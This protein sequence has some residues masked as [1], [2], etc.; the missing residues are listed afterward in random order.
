[1]TDTLQE[2]VD[3]DEATA[4]DTAVDKE[5]EPP[6][7]PLVLRDYQ[8]AAADA[9]INDWG[10]D[11]RR[12][13]VVLPTGSGKTAVAAEVVRRAR[14]KG[15]RVVM[16]AHR[17]ELLGQMRNAVHAVDPDIGEVGVVMAEYNDPDPDIVVASFQTLAS[18]PKRL[19]ALGKRD[20]IVVDEC[21][22]ITAPTYM[23]VL[24]RLGAG[25]A[26]PQAEDESTTPATAFTLGL[27]A[28][29]YRSDGTALGNVWENVCFER[30]IEWAIDNGFLV[31]PKAK[32]VRVP[33]L[34]G[35][36]SIMTVAGDYNKAQLS[37]IMAKSA[38][39]N[40][41]VDAVKTHAADR[42][43]IVFAASV[44]H[45]EVLAEALTQA[46]VPSVS[47]TGSDPRSVRAERYEKFHSGEVGALVTVMVLTE[48]AD[49]PRCDCVVMARP[50]RSQVL[51]SQMI[52]RALR[53]YTDPVTGNKKTDALVLDLTGT[54]RDKKLVTL[55]DLWG[56]A[57]TSSY[58]P[59]GNLLPDPEV[60][61]DLP[62]VPASGGET[63][64]G[65][66]AGDVDLVDYDL[67]RS[68]H[69]SDNV[70]VLLSPKG[71][72]FVP[73]GR[74]ASGLA[75]WPPTPHQ[76]QRVYLLH[77]T[78]DGVS[79]YQDSNGSPIT[80]TAPEMTAL[81][82]RVALTMPQVGGRPQ[83]VDAFAP[84]RAP[85]RRPTASQ[86]DLAAKVG[87]HITRSMSMADVSDAISKAIF[88]GLITHH[89][90]TI[91]SL[92]LN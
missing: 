8:L 42:A 22:H 9:V 1:M 58:D 56:S 85:Q 2:E 70:L 71:L 75:L 66:D 29:M 5:P 24:A 47:V 10:Q 28:T 23:S 65:E 13:A 31:A 36:G 30:D 88:E 37:E 76:A 60:D 11:I 78:R 91:Q 48:G 62:P 53:L 25:N 34:D 19:Q 26:D 15:L 69:P 6:R 41:V 63:D 79:V 35:L 68:G 67:R 59:D 90:F 17:G 52:G 86:K 18:S 33:E 20:V 7:S 61:P 49:F 81:A 57:Q 84:W 73:S 44:P 3:L 82:R 12:T 21:H 40:A 38:S 46:G 87:V 32:T 72:V 64:D 14:E 77:V 51:Y 27:T 4:D 92:G 54:V 55:T 50:T 74:G 89:Y 80:G 39:V 43:M 16:L 83:W 45:A